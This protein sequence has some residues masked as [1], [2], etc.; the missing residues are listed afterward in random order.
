MRYFSVPLLLF[1]LVLSSLAGCGSDTIPSSIESVTIGPQTWMADNLDTGRYRNGDP[2]RH[3]RTEEEWHDALSRGEGAWCFYANRETNRTR[4]GRLYNWYAVNDPRGL[5]PEGWRIASDHDWQQLTDHLGGALKAGGHLKSPTGWNRPNTGADNS[6]LFG[7][8]PAGSRNCL[9]S[10]YGKG[11]YAYFWTSTQAGRF[12]AWNR[13]LSSTN[14]EV[15]R[16]K[17]NKSLGF[18]VRCI[19]NIPAATKH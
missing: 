4:H 16:V 11:R 12:D 3:A 19:K 10:F 18:S 1:S 17:V 9:G 14:S 2:V 7:A 13:E 15:R 6:T 5:A 8:L